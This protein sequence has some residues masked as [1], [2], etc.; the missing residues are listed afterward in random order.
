MRYLAASALIVLYLIFCWLC[1]RNSQ[2]KKIS[3]VAENSV[4]SDLILIGY[5]SQTGSAAHIAQQTAQQ[6]E[7]AGKYV[8]LL[9]LNQITAELLTQVST[10]L[11]ITSTYGEGEAPDNGNRFIARTLSGLEKN[12]LDHQHILILGLGDSA[13]D[14]FCGFAHKLQHAL[15]ERGAHF[16]ADVIEVDLLDESALRYW[17]YYLGQISGNSHFSDWSKPAYEKWGIV[18]RECVNPEGI[19]APAFHIQLQP[20]QGDITPDLWQAGDVV[21]VGPCNSR[22]AITHFSERLGREITA[23]LLLTREL[24]ISDEKLA[25]L[26]LQDDSALIES[27][28]ELPHREYSIA[29]VPSEGSLDLLVRQV[30]DAQN[31][32]GLGSGWLT[33]FAGVNQPIRLRIRTSPHF[34]APAP[35]C[36]LILIGNGTGIAGLRAHIANPTRVNSRQWLFFGERSE[37]TDNFFSADIHRWQQDGRLTRADKIFSRDAQAGAPRY[38]QDLL[39]PNAQ[40]IRHWVNEG[41]AIFVCGS[42]HGMAQAVDEALAEILGA[43][44][45]ESLAD[46][47]RYCRDVY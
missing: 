31:Q 34:H 45:L 41:A 19:G 8:Q 7:Q 25:A 44:Q 28:T 14:Y 42:L 2:R 9:P 24:S 26:A 4:V 5:A 27:L 33:Q 43:D 12:A 39:R 36:P 22:A 30:R 35:V 37:L 1:W 21:E 16:M 40:E 47:R 10:A 38:V 11:F 46:Q 6:L 15:H 23:E 3:V 13:Y 17:Q 29:S 20:M 18:A 32:L